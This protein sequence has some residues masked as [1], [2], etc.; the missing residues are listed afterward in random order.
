[1]KN[2]P[3]VIKPDKT[4]QALVPINPEDGHFD[5]SGRIYDCFVYPRDK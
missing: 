1:M 4:G 3:F 5:D 2:K